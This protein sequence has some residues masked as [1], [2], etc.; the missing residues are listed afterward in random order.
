MAGLKQH[1]VPVESLAVYA[2]VNGVVWNNPPGNASIDIPT[3]WTG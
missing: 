2:D 1:R 3:F